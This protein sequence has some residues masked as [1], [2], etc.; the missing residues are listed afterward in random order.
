MNVTWVTSSLA[1][2]GVHV[3]CENAAKAVAGL[4][5]WNV[6]LAYSSLCGH[7]APVLPGVHT[8]D[9]DILNGDL[10][11][12]ANTFH[13]WLQKHPQDVLLMNDESF[14]EPYWPY[15]PP[16][17]AVIAVLHEVGY[18]WT[19]SVFDYR[20]ALDGV[21][22]VG[23]HIEKLVRDK[24]PEW[25]GEVRTIWNGLHYPPTGPRLPHARP[26]NLTFVGRISR[27]KGSSDLASVL[28]HL[29][30]LEVPA[31]LTVIGGHS[32]SL[33]KAF[34]KAGV[35]S[36]VCWAGVLP[37]EEVFQQLERSDVFLMPSRY[38]PFGLVTIEA[39]AMG[40]V[41]VG[42][43][44][45]G[46]PEEVIEHENTGLLVPLGNTRQ[47]AKAVEQLHQNREEM[48]SMANAAMQRARGVFSAERMGEKY[49]AFLRSVVE[50]RG[51]PQRKN[52]SNFVVPRRR[53]RLY[54][55][56]CPRPVRRLLGR[57]LHGSPYLAN[58]LRK[59]RGR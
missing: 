2:G 26:L 36:S 44:E 53:T 7:E 28:R 50:G 47:M 35:A 19:R 24:M 41:P 40:S 51:T 54:A 18:A 57:F 34:R 45:S 12:A 5:D 21:V 38:E 27:E 20:D 22:T 48:A 17:V 46:G 59:W 23:H 15:V 39:M 37:R 43:L 33:E 3:V 4:T 11:S 16:G 49:V 14:L 25:P 1:G 58:R 42:Y 30:D 52:F 10:R 29:A 6:N 56:F 8:H 55:R 32:E 9:L 13:D 31:R